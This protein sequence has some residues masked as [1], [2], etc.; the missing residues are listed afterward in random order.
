M[1]E[2]KREDWVSIDSLVF[3]WPFVCLLWEDIFSLL[4]F[5]SKGKLTEERSLFLL[6]YKRGS[7]FPK[8]FFLLLL[9]SQMKS[10]FYFFLSE[11][12][13][14]LLPSLS[15]W[16]VI[17][18]ERTLSNVK[19]F[20]SDKEELREG[21]VNTVRSLAMNCFPSLLPYVWS[22]ANSEEGTETMRQSWVW[23]AFK[24][25]GERSYKGYLERKISFL[26][27]MEECLS[28][29][30]CFLFRLFLVFSALSWMC[31]TQ[32]VSLNERSFAHIKSSNRWFF[33]CTPLPSRSSSSFPNV[34][35]VCLLSEKFSQLVCFKSQGH[36]GKRKEELEENVSPWS[37]WF[38]PCR[39]I[40]LLFSR[41]FRSFSPSTIIVIVTE[42]VTLFLRLPRFRKAVSKT[43]SRVKWKSY[44][45]ACNGCLCTT[46]KPSEKIHT[47]WEN[48]SRWERNE[49]D[50]KSLFPCKS[51]RNRN[52]K[53]VEH[54]DWPDPIGNSGQNDGDY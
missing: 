31:D 30:W 14:S 48:A 25:R 21:K 4:Q 7:Q 16:L 41:S 18:G 28:F 5:L 23:K 35:I 6:L 34:R 32:A 53:S 47:D 13:L 10:T 17:K 38:A 20:T 1:R 11:L 33:I 3:N 42:T 27:E 8:P 43:S 51:R 44:F 22:V 26:N 24:R 45:L 37:A 39:L 19:T 40:F 15:E 36:R 12:P 54:K 52:T 46:D 49:I 29:E 9:P 50:S 2:R